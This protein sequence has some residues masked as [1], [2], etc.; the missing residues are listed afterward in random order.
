LRGTEVVSD[1]TNVLALECARRLLAQPTAAVQLCTVHQ[2]TRA[3]PLP[4][5]AGH[6]RHFRMFALVDAG[7]GSA[8][9]GFELDAIARQLQVFDRLLDLAAAEL[10]CV[11]PDRRVI[12]RT[13]EAHAT[14]GTRLCERLRREL[15]HVALERESFSSAYYAGVRVGF[16]PRTAAGEFCAIGDIGVFDWMAKLTSHR[17][18][19]FLAGGFG[20]QLLPLLF[21]K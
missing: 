18:M 14:L 5:R 10:P 19:R 4:P 11:Y 1:P 20:L 2:V 12:V 8:E 15:P 13:D 17:K 21:A 6:T 16:G 3:Q 7:P 9:D